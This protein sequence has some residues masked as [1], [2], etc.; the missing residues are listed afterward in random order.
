MH[1]HAQVMEGAKNCVLNLT[2]VKE[3]EN[4]LIWTDR[5]GK[6]DQQVIDVL[7]IVIEE[8]GAKTILLNE[9]PPIFRLGEK[10][11]GPVRAALEK[12]DAVIHVLEL[13]NAASIDNIYIQQI[14]FEHPVRITACICPRV[15]LMASAWAR[16][17]LG[18][19][20]TIKGM[21][22]EKAKGGPFLLTDA[23]GTDLTGT[24]KTWPL[25]Q[26]YLGSPSKREGSWSFF[27][28]GE[29]VHHPES[30]LNGRVIFETLEGFKG[31]LREPV[32]LT[33]KDHWVVEVEGGPDARWLKKMMSK[34]EN[35]NYFCELAWGL[36]PKA[37][38]SLGLE[39]KAPDTILYR[40]S[41]VFHCGLGLWP[42]V[43]VPCLFHWD[44]G[45]LR[46]T[47]YVGEELIIDKG[48]LT[49]LDDPRL[50]EEARKYGDPEEL[51]SEEW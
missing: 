13:E 27:P 11:S 3:G 17:P 29:I 40:R 10:L 42:G 23:N 14:L 31:L 44:G 37:S 5:S 12:A 45:G 38:I 18:L 9:K 51:L 24:L 6:V 21:V 36:N 26:G 7:L 50:I 8:A 35:G 47:L 19:F 32:R 46:P 4:I 16:F 41:G 20:N 25:G 43:G 48:H 2:K 1:E 15:E 22:A 34:Y 33:V 28:P 30:P 39:E 49:I